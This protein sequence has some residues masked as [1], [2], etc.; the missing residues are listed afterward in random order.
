MAQPPALSAPESGGA[1][2]GRQHRPWPLRRRPCAANDAV[3]YPMGGVLP[4]AAAVRLA[5]S[6]QGL[7]GAAPASSAHACALDNGFCPQQRAVLLGAAI[8]PGAQ[9]AAHPVI[10]AVV[11]RAVGTRPVRFQADM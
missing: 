9:R 3:M 5:A 6:D 2:L 4:D 11:Y 10:R 1:V 7:A 8:H